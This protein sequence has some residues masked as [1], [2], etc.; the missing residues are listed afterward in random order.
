MKEKDPKY[1]KLKIIEEYYFK[2]ITE[3]ACPN[4]IKHGPE[5]A[6]CVVV[7]IN[8]YECIRSIRLHV[9]NANG[10]EKSVEL[11]NENP[12]RGPRGFDLKQSGTFSGKLRRTSR[13]HHEEY[14]TAYIENFS[15]KQVKD[16]NRE[17]KSIG[18][19]RFVRVVRKGINATF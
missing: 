3:D 9:F 1:L 16:K 19:S 13:E 14:Y 15:D 12:Q 7:S 4:L 10:Q 11:K 2:D 6:A 17:W 5:K 8:E 18:P